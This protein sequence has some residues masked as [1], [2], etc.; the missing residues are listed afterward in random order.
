LQ[1]AVLFSQ[2]DFGWRHIQTQ[3]AQS[4]SPLLICINFFSWDLVA[5]KR[6]LGLFLADLERKRTDNALA[7]DLFTNPSYLVRAGTKKLD[8]GRTA[9]YRDAIALFTLSFF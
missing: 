1:Y 5:A 4:V 2:Y 9:G 3:I 8:Q 6:E 7:L